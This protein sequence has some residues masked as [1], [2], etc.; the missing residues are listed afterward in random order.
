[1]PDIESDIPMQTLLDI[2]KKFPEGLSEYNLISE[3]KIKLDEF[4][5]PERLDDAQ[6]LFKL[7]FLLFHTLYK[8]RDQL[9][10]DRQG[11][12]ELGPLTI[13]LLP[14]IEGQEALSVHEP[15]REYY[16]DISQLESTT[17][18]DV[19]E[20]LASFW[21]KFTREDGREEA[22]EQLGLE[23]PVDDISIKNRYRELVMEHHPDRGGE[24]EQLQLINA[25]VSV[26]LEK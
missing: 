16:L 8:L 15:L 4:E 18:Q 3:L 5:V 20:M 17:E 2:L 22:L 19:Y 1:M 14:Y 23:D 24:K 21:T 9:H 6:G 11:H 13:R 26:L 10:E 25:A 12:L 7:H